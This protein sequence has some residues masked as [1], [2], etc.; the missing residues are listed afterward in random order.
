MKV[1][2]AVADGIGTVRVAVH[3]D[4]TKTVT[5]DAPDDGGEPSLA[6]DPAY[7]IKLAWGGDVAPEVIARETALIA[8]S[9]ATRRGVATPV[10]SIEAADLDA[11]AEA[12]RP[13]GKR[14]R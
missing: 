8:S 3:I 14:Q 6:P 12:V 7:I 13:G 1:L 10:A 11:L 5:L 4:E 9:E 2:Q